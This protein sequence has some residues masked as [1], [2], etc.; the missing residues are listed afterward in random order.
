MPYDSEQGDPKTALCT[1]MNGKDAGKGL[2]LLF[3]GHYLKT[4]VGG[5]VDSAQ[6]ARSGMPVGNQFDYGSE[7]QKNK[8]EGPIPEGEYWISPSEIRSPGLSSPLFLINTDSWGFYRITI[9]RYAGTNTHG[10][11]GFF[12]HGGDKFGSK[13]CIDLAGFMGH[14][15]RRLNELVP[16]RVVQVPQRVEL[17]STCYIP[18][19]VKYPSQRVDMPPW[20]NK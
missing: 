20:F 18:L 12:I 8:D 19:T 2:K 5:V 17:K 1:C 6:H 15:V 4:H 13:G 9:H 3:D 14:F 10:R 11:G 7:R 16:T